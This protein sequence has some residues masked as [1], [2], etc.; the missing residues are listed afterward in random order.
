DFE[1]IKG[2]LGSN[3]GVKTAKGQQAVDLVYEL[4]GKKLGF[5]LETTYTGKAM[6]AMFDF[7]E[8][9]EN[10]SKKVL[11]WNTYNSNDLDR[12]LREIIS[13]LASYKMS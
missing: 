11:F 8:K 7:F 2:Y 6:A 13:V 4:E 12:Y 5:K 9:E 3:Y 10:K 1:M